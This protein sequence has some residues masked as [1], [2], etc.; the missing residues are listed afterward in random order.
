MI[1]I[2]KQATEE[3]LRITRSEE[4][5]LRMQNENLSAIKLDEKRWY[6]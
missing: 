4:I 2:S 5:N 6:Y 3:L 1:S